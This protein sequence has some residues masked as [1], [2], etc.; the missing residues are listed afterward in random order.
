MQQLTRGDLWPSHHSLEMAAAAAVITCS[1]L[2]G[3]AGWIERVLADA[4]EEG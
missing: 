4:A 1:V 2:S 3:R